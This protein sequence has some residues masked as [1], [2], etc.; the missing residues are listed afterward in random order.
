[1]LLEDLLWRGATAVADT[2]LASL[3]LED[4]VGSVA[5]MGETFPEPIGAIL[6]RMNNHYFCH[7]G[8]ASAIRQIL[9]RATVPEVMAVF[10]R[11][12]T[13]ELCLR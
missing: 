11:C 12:L 3:T 7:M 8:E 13:I 5:F 2:H 10:H 4:M 9:D 1:M 6:Q